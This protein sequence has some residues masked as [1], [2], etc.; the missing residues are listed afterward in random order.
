MGA[1]V[2]RIF[3]SSWP[4]LVSSADGL[5][6]AIIMRKKSNESDPQLP[7]PASKVSTVLELL[8][9]ILLNGTNEN[10]RCC[11]Y[12][13]VKM[14]MPVELPREDCV[15]RRA[16]KLV[17]EPRFEMDTPAVQAR[18]T[19]SRSLMCFRGLSFSSATRRGS[20]VGTTRPIPSWTPVGSLR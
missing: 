5:F 13:K 18:L 11:K 1:A 10:R 2:V 15:W 17:N 9:K 14:I 19:G 20:G 12:C 3:R 16:W 6:L 8:H 4:R 7:F